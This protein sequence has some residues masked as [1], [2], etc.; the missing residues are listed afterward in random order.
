MIREPTRGGR[1]TKNVNQV[2]VKQVLHQIC[3]SFIIYLKYTFDIYF[4][5]RKERLSK[6]SPQKFD[7]T[8]SFCVNYACSD[9]LGF[10][11]A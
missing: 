8:N 7:T 5:E 6:R 10:F 9:F 3:T 4:W 2:L 1:E 11:F